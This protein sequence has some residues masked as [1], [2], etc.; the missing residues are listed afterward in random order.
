M[1]QY[2]DSGTEQEDQYIRHWFDGNLQDAAAAF[3]TQS[4]YFAYGSILPF[5][6]TIRT[7]ARAGNVVH[8]VLGANSGNLSAQDLTNVF[9][10][11]EGTREGRVTVV[12]FSGAEFHPKCYHI[13]RAD[14]SQTAVVGS[15]NLTANGVSAN[16]EAAIVLD[17]NG[18]DDPIL[19][20]NIAEAIDKWVKAVAADGAYQITS[21]QDIEILKKMRLIDLL[22]TR[23]VPQRPL[24]DSTFQRSPCLKQRKRY[25]KTQRQT[26]R[27]M[28]PPV[29]EPVPS[30]PGIVVNRWSKKLRRTDAMRN[31]GHSI[32]EL[33]LT[34]AG[35]TIDQ[36]A[37]FR[38]HFFETAVW[39]SKTMTSRSRHAG[40]RRSYQYEEAQLVFHVTFPTFAQPK[41]ERLTIVHMPHREFGQHNYVTAI[42]W[43]PILAGELR[44][45][46]GTEGFTGKWV[47]MELYDN[48]EYALRIGDEPPTPR[49]I[50]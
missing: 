32:N 18:G 50:I 39:Q 27:K 37:F 17:T 1:A 6:E 11:L 48:G 4:G 49:L 38:R 3:R 24:V 45:A 13:L 14:G 19:L 47:I 41:R 15:G 23:P 20:M 30:L 31:V 10:I 25:W 40:D 43:G 34:K 46:P 9:R 8:L 44:N 21:L 22:E 28:P 7:I 36:T 16:V 29:T 33:R 26:A 35:L 42:K 12:A 2:I 5:A